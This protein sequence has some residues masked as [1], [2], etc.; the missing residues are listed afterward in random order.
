MKLETCI[1]VGAALFASGCAAGERPPALR[2]TA[3][4]SE[5]DIHAASARANP[6]AL[7]AW[8]DASRR[9][10]R[11]G[12]QITP[13]FRERIVFPE[14]REQAIAYRVTLVRGQSLRVHVAPGDGAAAVFTDMFHYVGRDMF[15]PVHWA[16]QSPGSSTFVARTDGEYVLRL[17]PPI[18]AGGVYDVALLSDAALVFPVSGAG[19]SSIGGVFGDPRDNGTRAH[20]GVDIFA[21]RGTAVVAVADG[22]IETS[23]NTPT[24][25]LVIWQADAGSALTYYYAHLDELLVRERAYV[26]AGDIIGRVGNTGNARGTRPHLHFAIYRPGKI[27]IDPVP[28]LAARARAELRDV[29]I[30]GRSLGA[31]TRANGDGVRLRRSPSPAGSVITELSPATPLLVV[32][33]TGDWQRVVLP[34]GTTG[35]VAAHMTEPA[36]AGSREP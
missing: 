10:L 20:E 13:S 16:R 35:F 5:R 30:H 28:Q 3:V 32:G 15:R 14:G 26:R 25:G 33:D 19:P 23:R 18:G 8:E 4:R 9:A 27:A 31:V 12:L 36:Y 34:D 6:A 2:P 7:R 17:Q 11:S 22:R 1:F 21:P 29:A 24:G